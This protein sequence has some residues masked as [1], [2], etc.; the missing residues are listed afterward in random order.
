MIALYLVYSGRLLPEIVFLGGKT[1][2]KR[3]IITW[4][5]TV[6]LF[7]LAAI[8]EADEPFVNISTTPDEVDLGTVPLTNIYDVPG[9]LTV[10]VE[11]NCVHGP[12]MISSTKLKRR[13]G[14]SI[15]P[16]RIFVKSPATNGFIAMARPV[17]ISKP[18]I[19]SHT[20]VL[21][22]RV[23]ADFLYPAGEYSGT[24]MLT[25]MPPS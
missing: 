1:K 2:M 9:A 25:M 15:S 14:G 18:T 23:E 24:L 5:L 13:Q 22:F 6:G 11:S 4:A 17:T 10:N 16:E 8:T 21:D 19:G 7:G 12:I 20:I 3:I